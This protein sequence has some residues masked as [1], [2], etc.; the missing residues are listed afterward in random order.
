LARQN[1]LT[2]KQIE[3]GDIFFFFRPK[4][5]VTERVKGIEDVQKFY[6]VTCPEEGKGKKTKAIYRL[7]LL[8]AK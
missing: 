7:F 8:G 6:M 1:I 4:I 2:S 3:Q 5:E